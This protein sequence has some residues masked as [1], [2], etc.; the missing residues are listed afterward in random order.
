MTLLEIL[1]VKGKQRK[2]NRHCI[3]KCN[4]CEK[5]WENSHC[6]K[7]AINQ[8]HHFCSKKCADISYRNGGLT[9][10]K[11]KLTCQ[12]KYGVDNPRQNEQIKQNCKQTC[13]EKYG[14][15]NPVQSKEVQDK[16]KATCLK[17]YGHENP[18]HG[19][20]AQE[21]IKATM[22]ERFGVE[23]AMQNAEI[24]NK[25]QKVRRR[26]KI[27]FH[28]K[29]GEELTCVASYEIAFVN[30]CNQN[31]IDF[32]WQIQFE[33][34]LLTPGGKFAKYTI[35]AHILSGEFADT[36]IEIKGRE[37]K[38]EKWEWFHSTHL[39]S[40]LWNLP[41]LKELKIL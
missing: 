3:L 14:C 2:P 38:L 34:P 1:F 13:Q 41:R 12:I 36:W 25:N 28:W 16:T 33:T 39:N 24:F 9:R 23:N 18:A 15:D 31:K 29:T 10:N 11:S 37:N 5:E 8:E 20:I 6:V 22:L 26:A 7:Q 27:L 4:F 19:K 35:D 30:W 21:K 17:R 32:D 40:Q